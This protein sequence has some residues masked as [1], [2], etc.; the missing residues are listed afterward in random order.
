VLGIKYYPIARLFIQVRKKNPITVCSDSDAGG[1]SRCQALF[2]STGGG[3]MKYTCKSYFNS[4]RLVVLTVAALLLGVTG[5]VIAAKPDKPPC[6]PHCDDPGEPPSIVP[7]EAQWGGEEPFG[8]I[9]E[10]GTRECTTS[11]P[12]ASADFGSYGCAL[13]VDNEIEYGL[14]PGLVVRKNQDARLCYPRRTD[15]LLMRGTPSYRYVY[16]WEGD[17]VSED[18]CEI[19]VFNT[20]YGIGS[21]G[22]PHPDELKEVG[23]V[24]MVASGILV[25]DENG[26]PNPNP[27]TEA[28]RIRITE[29]DIDFHEVGRDKKIAT[30][31]WDEYVEIGDGYLGDVYLDTAPPA[32]D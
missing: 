14:G 22:V 20:F 7:N 24:H 21:H 23:L 16:S 28:R 6:H 13:E 15:G 30:C 10:N 2:Y 9:T 4:R 17:C 1:A 25:D 32:G 8:S 26:F 29:I 11:G 3:P 12:A 19:S 18:G 31:H 5:M 27:F